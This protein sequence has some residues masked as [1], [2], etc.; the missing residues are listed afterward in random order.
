MMK[1]IHLIGIGGSGMSSIAR[2]LL[3]QGLTVSGSDRTLSPL[4]LNLRAAWWCVLPPSL[5][6]T[7]KLPQPS[8]WVSLCSSARISCET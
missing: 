4:A 7:L 3:E 1:R 5:M 2:V 6:I 8:H